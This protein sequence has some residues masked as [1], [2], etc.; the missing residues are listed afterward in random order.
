[1]FVPNPDKSYARQN[2]VA[3][4]DIRESEFVFITECVMKAVREAATIRAAYL[5][6][7]CG[8][9]QR[10][11]CI[12]ASC[13]EGG[14]STCLTRIRTHHQKI[15]SAYGPRMRIQVENAPEAAPVATL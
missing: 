11:A 14:L 12:E 1:M 3:N 4:I 9:T 6:L 7:F 13:R 10:Q 8:K 5:V 15:L 2:D